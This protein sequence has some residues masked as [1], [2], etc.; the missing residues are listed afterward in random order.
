MARSYGDSGVVRSGRGLKQG[1][2]RGREDRT[3][4]EE[5]LE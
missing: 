2:E 5:G 1:K 3:R 4:R